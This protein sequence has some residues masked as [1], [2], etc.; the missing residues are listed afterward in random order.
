MKRYWISCGKMVLCMYQEADDE[1][2]LQEEDE[3]LIAI[4][5]PTIDHG[6]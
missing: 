3:E 2:R 4:I 1:Q 6:Q 5:L